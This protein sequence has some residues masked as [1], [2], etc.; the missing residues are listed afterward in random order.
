MLTQRR[1]WNRFR[2][3]KPLMSP[4]ALRQFKNLKK[5]KNKVSEHN[6]VK[7]LTQRPRFNVSWPAESMLFQQA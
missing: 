4:S 2:P 6:R 5:G 7:A 3:K 1:P